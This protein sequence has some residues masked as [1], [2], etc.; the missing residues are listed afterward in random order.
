MFMPFEL[1]GETRLIRS[2][3]KNWRPDNFKKFLMIQSH[4]RSKNN[5]VR[6]KDF[7]DDFVQRKSLTVI[8]QSSEDC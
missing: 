1:E 4:E 3:I 6:L 5:L 8:F 2:T 7:C